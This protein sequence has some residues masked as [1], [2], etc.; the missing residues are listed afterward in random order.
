MGETQYTEAIISLQV[1]VE[2]EGRLCHIVNYDPELRG[3]VKRGF[4]W[5]GGHYYASGNLQ[6]AAEHIFRIKT[7]A[8]LKEPPKLRKI[9]YSQAPRGNY[10]ANH[11]FSAVA[12][13]IETWENPEIK[14]EYS[15]FL[16]E[17]NSLVGAPRIIH[18]V[19]GNSEENNFDWGINDGPCLAEVAFKQSKRKGKRVQEIL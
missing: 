19:H 8:K 18:R 17:T 16:V 12:E 3:D 9:I 14:S 4:I 1:S 6:E 10:L 7:G 5:P 13:P 15:V 11:A 2:H